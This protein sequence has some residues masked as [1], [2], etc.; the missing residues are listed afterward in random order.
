MNQALKVIQFDTDENQ[1][2]TK[3]KVKS[4]KIINSVAEPLNYAAITTAVLGVISLILEIKLFF[5]FSYELYLA[6]LIPTIFS[7]V[8]LILLN[9]KFGRK[10]QIGLV[11]VYL[12]AMIFSMGFFAYRV[13]EFYT[14]NL[15]GALLLVLVLSQFLSWK[16]INQ[17]FVTIYFSISFLTAAII[18]GVFQINNFDTWIYTTGVLSLLLIPVLPS[19]FMI[20][21]NDYK[22]RGS[23]H[24]DNEYDREE[25]N[26]ASQE[27]LDRSISPLFQLTFDGNIKYANNSFNEILGN[28]SEEE[29]KNFNFFKHFVRNDNI[30]SHILKKLENKGRIEN[31]RLTIQSSNGTE[32]VYLMDCKVDINSDE[33]Q[34]IEGSIKNITQIHNK[35]KELVKEISNKVSAKKNSPTV[36][37]NYSTKDTKK[38]NL[39]SKLGHELRT[40]MNSVLGFLTL[41]ENGLFETEEELKEFSRSAKLSAQSL[42][43]LLTDILELSKIDDGSV[44]ILESEVELRSE[45][46]KLITAVGPH[47][48]EKNLNLNLNISDN[49]PE[50]IISD[51]MKYNQVVMN[52][53]SNAI[54][55]TEDG[56]I[57]VLISTKYHGNNKVEIMTVVEDSGEG[58][59]SSK[60]DEMLSTD[61]LNGQTK[62]KI[63]T[64]LLRIIIC[65]ELIN[66]LGGKLFAKSEVGKGSRFVFSI[67]YTDRAE[68]DTVVNENGKEVKVSKASSKSR[69]LLVED[70]PISR[71]VEKKLLEEA[72]YI[73]DCVNN[74]LDAIEKVSSGEYNLVLMDIE[75]KELNGLETTKKIR[76][77][78]DDVNNIPIVAVTAHSSM[79][80]REK[81][82][83][84]GMNDYISKPINITFLK[85]TIDQW[86]NETRSK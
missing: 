21:T 59:E 71:K 73:V 57:K 36:V 82:L 69:L 9:I 22:R 41:I 54:D 7:F 78:P 34:I 6:R 30:Q 24:S 31:Y 45:I 42:L 28:L 15:M 32:D 80:D 25:D 5:Q 20:N 79:K 65:R 17:I 38:P 18:S 56:E 11:H 48:N 49:V 75:L 77:L 26:E 84:A 86:L 47:L 83:L 81:C 52:L 10:H 85:M 27:F 68:H 40:P 44:D 64:P 51:P 19:Y 76:E 29:L 53:I 12:T 43:N 39:I 66:L 55:A 62:P 63:T 23:N 4:K 16:P 67:F 2:L 14:Y 13:P 37:P 50:K 60:L 1:E 8:T 3:S 61:L 46:E 35:E 74:G 70:N 58:M 33:N 72:G